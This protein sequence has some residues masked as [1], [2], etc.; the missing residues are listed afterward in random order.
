MIGIITKEEVKELIGS[1]NV[2]ILDVRDLPDYRKEH[3]PGALHMFISDMDK[4]APVELDKNKTIIIY[5]EDFN[6]PASAMAVQRLSS[7]GYDELRDY[8]GSF[9][10]WKEA[11]Y[12][13]EKG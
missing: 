3:L 2:I 12:P 7:L 5:S 9:K 6:C 1:E 13:L 10:D 4:R 11:G 8:S